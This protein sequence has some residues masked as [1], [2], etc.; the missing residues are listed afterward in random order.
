M[1]LDV[2]RP[3]AERVRARALERERRVWLMLG[4][5]GALVV[6]TAFVA[7]GP[8]SGVGTLALLSALLLVR[9]M[10]TRPLGSEPVR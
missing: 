10:V 1:A 6:A 9:A 7:V 8:R 4:G 2:T 5:I 3:P